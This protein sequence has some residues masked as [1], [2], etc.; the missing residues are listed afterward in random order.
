MQ[1][2]TTWHGT[3]DELSALVAVVRHHCT[4]QV[5]GGSTQ[6][7]CGAHAMLEH[8]QRAVDGLVWMRRLAGRLRAEEAVRDGRAGGDPV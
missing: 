2:R 8:D 3:P 5:V 1:Q 7:A 4:C 6:S